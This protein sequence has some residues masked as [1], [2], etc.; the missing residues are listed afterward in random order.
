MGAHAP[1]AVPAQHPIHAGMVPWIRVPCMDVVPRGSF[2]VLCRPMY[3][4]RYRDIGIAAWDCRIG[5]LDAPA[6]WRAVAGSTRLAP[7]D[8]DLHRLLSD[9]ARRPWEAVRS[10]PGLPAWGLSTSKGDP[11]AFTPRDAASAGPGLLGARIAREF[12][13][14]TYVP[15]ATAAACSTGLYALLA[16]ADRLADG[17]CSRGLAGAAD[18][19]L[20][21]WL[22]AGFARMGVLCESGEP[23]AFDGRGSGFVPSP[24]AGVIALTR[25]PAP[26][27][28]VAG[29]RLG[30]AGHETHFVDPDTLRTALASLWEELP[31][32]DLIVAHATGTALGDAYELAG[33]ESG[34]WRSAP[35]LAL[36]PLIGHTL[37][38]SGAVELALALEAPVERLWKLSLGFGG[39]L[40]AVACC[41]S[42][43]QALP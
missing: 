9:A 17:T 43:R 16:C 33:L 39:H 12:G 38:A 23:S 13:T 10:G 26:W 25:Q 3:A 34:P 15:C 28:L 4:T 36:K 1:Q 20:P 37:G 2:R 35:R 41:R 24:G 18:G 14:G 42:E 30:D 32:P 22:R 8:G 11:W 19:D 31:E 27:R 21:P 6:A 7:A 5:G 29:V 40:A